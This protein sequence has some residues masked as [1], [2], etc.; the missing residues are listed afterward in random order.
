V[1]PKVSGYAVHDVYRSY[2]RSTPSRGDSIDDPDEVTSP[3]VSGSASLRPVLTVPARVGDAV[4]DGDFLR[5]DE[6]LLDQQPQDALAVFDG[7]GVPRS[8]TR[9]PSRSLA[10]LREASRSTAWASRASS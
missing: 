2:L 5:T 7:G 8:R 10:S 9:K 6:N 1:L 4:P 3:S